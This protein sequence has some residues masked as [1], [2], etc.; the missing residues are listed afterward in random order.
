D[1]FPKDKYEVY[2]TPLH[3]E[4][5]LSQHPFF[6][7]YDRLWQKG[8]VPLGTNPRERPPSLIV[9][10]HLKKMQTGFFSRL[11]GKYN[12]DVV[13]IFN[14]IAGEPA[15]K[16]E[17][18]VVQDHLVPHCK[19]TTDTFLIADA[20]LSEDRLS[21]FLNQLLSAY[22]AAGTRTKKQNLVVIL[23]KIDLLPFD[24]PVRQICLS[25]PFLLENGNFEEYYKKVLQVNKKLEVYFG[26]TFLNAYNLMKD[27]FQKMFFTGTSSMGSAPL[28][29]NQ[30]MRASFDIQ[31]IRVV[32]PLL[33]VLAE[34]N[35]FLITNKGK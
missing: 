4:S 27:S 34:A 35:H 31:P 1:G 23:T 19:R 10:F 8:I 24:H 33:L 25:Q 26:E 14:D 17:T 3:T 22:T 9:K 28:M 12:R 15:Q 13:C 11:V 16:A 32:D 6:T 2:C 18:W 5:D 30:E 29:F 20:S 7:P 21:N